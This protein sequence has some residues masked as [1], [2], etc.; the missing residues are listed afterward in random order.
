MNPSKEDLN[1]TNSQK[2]TNNIKNKDGFLK[3]TS[4]DSWEAGDG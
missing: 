1:I 2:K 3:C 4:A